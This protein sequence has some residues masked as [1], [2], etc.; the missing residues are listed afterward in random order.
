MRRAVSMRSFTVELSQGFFLSDREIIHKQF[1]CPTASQWQEQNEVKS[2]DGQ[3]A[4]TV[5]ISG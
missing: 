3:S 2:S 4:V 5:L 1:Q